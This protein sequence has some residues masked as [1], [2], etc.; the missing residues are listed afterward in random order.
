MVQAIL[1]SDKNSNA[2]VFSKK[3]QNYIKQ[4]KGYDFELYELSLEKFRNNELNLFGVSNL[5]GKSVYYVAD[6]SKSPND[7][8]AELLL[9]KDLVLNASA[10]S[11]SFV[12]PDMYYSRQDRK[13]EPRVPISARAV[14]NSISSGIKR[15][16]TMD[17]HAAQIQGFYP[18]NVPVDNLYSFPVV[19][20]YILEKYPEELKN[21]QIISPDAGGVDRAKSFRKRL[22]RLTPQND[23]DIGFMIKQRPRA[24]EVGNIKYIGEDYRGKNILII[25]DIVDSGGTLS[26]NA[27]MLRKGGAN[28]IFCY[29]THGL[30]TKGEEILNSQFDKVFTSNTR[31][32]G[33]GVEVI[34]ITPLFAEAIYRAEKNESVSELFE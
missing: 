6:S 27:E 11:L 33:N 28:K 3:I 30:F 10:Q 18:S 22:G 26:I 24:G 19:A 23:Y 31:Y 8:W 9:V 12:L 4:E 20:K 1:L 17:L 13:N 7:W 15:I 34:D 21:L 16:I 32:N 14:A 2:W 5:R 25:D 29:A